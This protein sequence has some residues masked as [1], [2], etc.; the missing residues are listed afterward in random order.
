MGLGKVMSI[1]PSLIF[2]IYILLNLYIQVYNKSC[3]LSFL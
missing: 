1:N 3:F 2:F